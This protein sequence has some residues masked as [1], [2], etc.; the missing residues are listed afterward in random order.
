VVRIWVRIWN[1][2]AVLLY[3]NF[4]IRWH[5]YGGI[6]ACEWQYLEYVFCD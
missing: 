3:V 1:E 5:W 6:L 4:C 2:E